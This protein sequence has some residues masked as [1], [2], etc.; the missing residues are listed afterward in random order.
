MSILGKAHLIINVYVFSLD[1][2]GHLQQD[3][4]VGV[5][6]NKDVHKS[7]I[8]AL[9]SSGFTNG[10]PFP[11]TFFLQETGKMLP[12]ALA[13][14]L[15]PSSTTISETPA[16][17]QRLCSP[18]QREVERHSEMFQIPWNMPCINRPS[19]VLD[20]STHKVC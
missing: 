6:E 14:C 18:E 20:H 16:L 15:F 17:S 10:L 1:S 2:V 4:L 12:L 7:C 3:K 13:Q 5:S 19:C 11:F 8:N 9:L